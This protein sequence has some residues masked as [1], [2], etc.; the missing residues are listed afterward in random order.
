M[1]AEDLLTRTFTEVTESTDYTTTP[2]ASV[3]ARYESRRGVLRRRRALVAAAAV[4]VVGGLSAS[5]ALAG[6]GGDGPPAP[7]GPLG[8]LEQG[9][10]PGVDYLHGDTFVTI[11]GTRIS[12]PILRKAHDAVAWRNGVLTASEPTVRHPISRISFVSGGATSSQGC[13]A[14]TFAL[15]TDGSDPTYWLISDCIGHPGGSLVSGSTHTPT[16]LGAILTP[17]GEV[18][19]GIVV[20]AS[21]P[22]LPGRASG[23][24]VIP[25]GHRR[26]TPL[27]WVSIARGASQ[28]ADLVAGD[29]RNIRSSVVVDASSGDVLWRARDWRLGKFSPSGRYVAGDQDDAVQPS[30][31][32]GDV[33]GVFDARTGHQVLRRELPGLALV[34]HPVW[35][36]DDALLVVVRDRDGR[37]AIVRVTLDGQVTR[38]TGVVQDRAPASS[39]P[40]RLTVLRLAA[41]P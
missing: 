12:S 34:G 6:G 2:L 15:S 4:V 13:G 31:N 5:L 40:A 29:G 7:A 10:A 32:V 33:V 37:E 38:A 23:T 17:V 9:A 39:S 41:T 25:P 19:G 11:S 3:V 24:Y 35:E 21:G 8:D 20:L 27:R 26:W 22:H 16:T 1:T 18:P 36:G 14:K 30:S 28:A